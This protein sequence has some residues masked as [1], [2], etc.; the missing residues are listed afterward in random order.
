M[1]PQDAPLWLT[2]YFDLKAIKAQGSQETIALLKLHRRI[3]IGG[4]SRISV[5]ARDHLHLSDPSIGQGKHL[6]TKHSRLLVLCEVHSFP[7]QSQ[8]PAPSS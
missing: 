2:D 6:I 1:P 8:S 7:L 3:Y 5:I 4:L